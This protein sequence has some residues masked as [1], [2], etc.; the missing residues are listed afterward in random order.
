MVMRGREWEFAWYDVRD[1]LPDAG[2]TAA[3]VV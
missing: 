1:V 2:T 3:F